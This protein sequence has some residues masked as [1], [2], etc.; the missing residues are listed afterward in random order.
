MRRNFIQNNF[1]K[2]KIKPFLYPVLLHGLYSKTK[3][4]NSKAKIKI[5][6]IENFKNKNRGINIFPKLLACLYICCIYY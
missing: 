2:E 6:N 3:I 4:L 5:L 1:E